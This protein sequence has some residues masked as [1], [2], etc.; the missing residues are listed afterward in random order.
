MLSDDAASVTCE[1]RREDR[2][3]PNVGA[4]VTLLFAFFGRAG[5]SGAATFGTVIRVRP[6]DFAV[7]LVPT[8]GGSATMVAVA[9]LAL[10][11]FVASTIIGVVLSSREDS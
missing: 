5:S 2:L 3:D 6:L 8:S 11:D 10:V 9:G 7:S 1:A 4:F